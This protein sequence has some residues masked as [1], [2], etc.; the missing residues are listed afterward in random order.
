MQDLFSRTVMDADQR[1]QY[2]AD[3]NQF[4]ELRLPRSQGPFPAVMVIHGGFWRAATDLRHMG[5]LCV[6]LTVDGIATFN[7]EYRRLGNAGGGWPGTLDDIRAAAAFL[8]ARAA[9]Y[10]ID[11]K[12][13]VAAGHSAGGQLALWLA[14]EKA[15]PLRGVV[16][17]AGIADLRRAHELNLGGGAVAELLGGGPDKAASRFKLASP[18][19]RL[20]LKI[21]VRLVHGINDSVVPLEIAKRFEAAARAARD[22]ARLTPL[23]GTGHFELIDPLAAQFRMV[24]AAIRGLLL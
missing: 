14:A 18:L 12:R 19:E 23:P 16:S 22:D 5:H 20:P 10:N 6:A 24:N 13:I 1:V 8:G 9:R 7:V 17:L 3:P 2:G 21:P 15:L 4:G 11:P